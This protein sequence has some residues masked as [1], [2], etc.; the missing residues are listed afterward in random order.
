MDSMT[1]NPTLDQSQSKMSIGCR[2]GY[3][4]LSLLPIVASFVLQ[5]GCMFVAIIVA[6]IIRLMQD[7]SGIADKEAYMQGFSEAYMEIVTGVASVGIFAYHIVG[8]LIFGLWY[9]LSFKKPRPTLKQSVKMVT[10][11]SI[12]ISV[13]GGI[14]LC[15]FANGTVVLESIF[16]P[17]IVEKF[18]K[19]A[20]MAG[21]GTDIWA[22]IATII[23]APIGEELL[24]RGVVLR[25]ANKCFGKFWLAN[26]LQAVL[27]GV[28]HA[29][30]VQGIYAF[31]IGLFL[32]WLVK[33]YKTI[34]PAML[35]HFVVNFSSSTWI[36]YLLEPVEPT[37]ACGILL[38][39]LPGVIG[40]GLIIW[41]QAGRKC[42]KESVL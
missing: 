11:K 18:N 35:V 4:F 29:N 25:Y 26:V 37:L 15:L 7:M 14:A 40:A 27:F 32:G 13:V 21:L 3:F 41:G 8:I 10:G 33:N 1:T 9:Y 20:E 28:L 23:L 31:V 42:E 36:A 19:M 2:I 24:C 6:T 12:F 5:F 17:S 38:T 39:L 30:W 22:I 16:L 34:I